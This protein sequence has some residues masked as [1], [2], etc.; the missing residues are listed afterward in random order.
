M[1][2]E[3][4][5]L[6]DLTFSCL[7]M[8]LSDDPLKSSLTGLRSNSL[9]LEPTWLQFLKSPLEAVSNKAGFFINFND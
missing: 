1:S 3:C 6:E 4:G 8:S 7:G 2:K 5:L 9:S